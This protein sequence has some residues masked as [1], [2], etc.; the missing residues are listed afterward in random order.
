MFKN[1]TIWI[2][3]GSKTFWGAVAAAV[4][5]LI[6]AVGMWKTDKSAAIN[7]AVTALG[8]IFA[9]IGIKDATSGPIN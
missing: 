6:A 8:L 9:A 5:M 2:L 3:L 7:Q 1:M 4:P